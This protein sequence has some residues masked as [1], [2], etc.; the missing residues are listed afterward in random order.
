MAQEHFEVEEGVERVVW[1]KN[2]SKTKFISLK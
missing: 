1:F 2:A